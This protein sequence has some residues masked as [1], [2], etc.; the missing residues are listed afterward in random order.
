MDP[1]GDVLL[2]WEMN[3]QPLPADHGAPLRVVVPGVAGCRSVKWVSALGASECLP[4]QVQWGSHC[5]GRGLS[6][7]PWAKCRPARCRALAL[8]GAAMATSPS[9]HTARRLP[10][11]RQLARVV[12]SKD[13]SS[14]FWQQK[15]YKSFSPSVDW[16]NVDWS[17][18]GCLRV[19]GRRQQRGRCH[20][21]LTP[22]RAMQLPVLCA[23]AYPRP[24]RSSCCTLHPA[25]RSPGHPGHA[26]DL[27][28]L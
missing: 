6:A 17:S 2:A 11:H 10:Q 16:D 20:T 4:C 24:T 28:H 3:G 7:A 25:W 26:G 22:V 18:G 21:L 9:P 5:R 12:A 13:E 19:P 23:A 15:D 14:S 8:L 27:S 1:R